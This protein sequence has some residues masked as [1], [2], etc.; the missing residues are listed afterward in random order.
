MRLSP[1]YVFSSLASR[2]VGLIIVVGLLAGSL[3]GIVAIQQTRSAMRDEILRRSLAAA[4]L[5]SA[6]TAEYFDQIE[7]DAREL[8]ARP[9]VQRAVA[10]GNYAQLD[11]DLQ[12][13]MPEHPH[14]QGLGAFD[15]NG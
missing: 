10:D 2:L 13:W 5:A 4:D 11:V 15:V 9:G 8:A 14:L 12:R 3:V 1:G 6:L 7:A